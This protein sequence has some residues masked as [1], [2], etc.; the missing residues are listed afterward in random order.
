MVSIQSRNDNQYTG[1]K[2]GAVY[3]AMA[4]A[5]SYGVRKSIDPLTKWVA[6]NTRKI[7]AE[8]KM[9]LDKAKV[10][11]VVIDAEEEVEL[12]HKMGVQKAPTLLV[13]TKKGVDVYD[14][15]SEIKRY[16]EGLKK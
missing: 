2:T 11:Y 9:I 8:R 16:I 13:P 6:N 14:N 5:A 15:A 12:T 10:K 7:A 4:G 3:T 1:L